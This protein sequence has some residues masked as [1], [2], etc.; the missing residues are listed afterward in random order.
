M[1]ATDDAAATALA[2]VALRSKLY[3]VKRCI[4]TP[5]SNMLVKTIRNIPSLPTLKCKCK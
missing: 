4:N 3:G 1:I 5:K 2:L